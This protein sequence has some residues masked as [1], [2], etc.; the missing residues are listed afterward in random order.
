MRLVRRQCIQSRE[1]D[2][3]RSRLYPLQK[4]GEGE[5]GIGYWVQGARFGELI[6][7]GGA[8]FYVVAA[9]RV[10]EVRSSPSGLLFRLPR[11]RW[12]HLLECR[13]G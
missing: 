7:A 5:G 11:L 1:T 8:R 12:D 9:E 13:A 6:R 2:R 3:C 4:E 10:E